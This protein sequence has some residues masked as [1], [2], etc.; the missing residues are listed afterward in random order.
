MRGSR[1]DHGLEIGRQ[2]F[3]CLGV[4]VEVELGAAFPPAGVVVERGDLVEAQLLVVVRAD[5][6]QAVERALFERGV[7]VGA[8][9]RL[10]D[11]AE[12]LEHLA[13]ERVGAELQALQV[14]D[15]LDFLA[16]PAA[17][18]RARVA[19]RQV[20]DVVLG[21][22]GAHQLQAVAFVHP[23]VLLA[24]V[25][26]ERHG[27]TQAE[28]R[29]LAVEVVRRR[30]RHFDRAALDAVDHAEGGHQLAARVH[31]DLELAARHVAHALREHLGGAEDGV[32]RL[33]KARC[34]TPAN[35]GLR[36]NR[37]RDAGSQNARDAGV[38]DEGT[39]IH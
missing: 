8:G 36:V 35:G 13:G 25:H 21:V 6:L 15:R 17:H 34:E 26:A 39:T 32:Q 14:G 5:P 37:G 30:V 7:Q 10:R 29:V 18:L 1:F 33:G 3:P 16:E 11:H 24:G 23:G 2:A 31:G 38:F 20:D 4:D 12:G 28:G 27:A 19:A 9:D 22:E